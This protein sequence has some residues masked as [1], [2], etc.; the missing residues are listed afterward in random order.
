MNTLESYVFRQALGPLLAIL[1]ALAAV[2]LLTQGLDRL[3]LIAAN[4]NS[5]FAFAWVTILA[6]PQLVSLILPLAIYF[7]VAYAINRM[8][9]E[10]E[11]VVAYSAGVSHG[12]LAK[13][14]LRLALA[15]AV[16]HLGVVLLVQP[17][18]Y[19]E[20]RETIYEVRGDVAA[21]LVR[22]GSFTFP[23]EDLTVYARERGPNGEMR[24]MMIH[25]AR[26]TRP[27]TYNASRGAVAMVDG[28]P[29]IIMR[30]AQVQRQLEDGTVQVV[31]FDQYLLELG[32][33]SV[34]SELFYLKPSDR[35]LLELVA[36]DHTNYFDQRNVD[37]LLAEA[38]YRLSS[39]L[40]DPALA[41][42]ALAGLLGGEFSRR[43]YAR[44]LVIA[45][46]TALLVRLAA[47]AIQAECV[48]NP[49]LNPLQY[50]LPLL[51]CAGAGWM[52]VFAHPRRPSRRALKR[53]Q[54]ELAAAGAGA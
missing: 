41:L 42:I 24:D 4:R 48:D 25:D 11:T 2:A 10:S 23:A 17:A 27:I 18:A 37:R 3:S 52:L 9:N 39:P 12:R 28:K 19:R 13:P 26:P 21:S 46:V 49:E 38:H 45:S 16:V 14:I 43:G 29:A 20:I 47:L 40:L 30:D 22:E 36:P 31:D 54:T 35:F 6:L 1:A 44:R 7:A 53:R 15:A 33:F 32:D 5:G 8:H 51:V 50:A 34:D